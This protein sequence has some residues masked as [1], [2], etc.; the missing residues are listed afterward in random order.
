MLL[1]D[2]LLHCGHMTILELSLSFCNVDKS[3]ISKVAS[4][5]IK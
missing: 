1:E 2:T 3:A 5:Q 4:F